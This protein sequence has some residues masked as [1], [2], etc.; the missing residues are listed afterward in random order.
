MV[1]M[2][3]KFIEISWN[4]LWRIVLMIALVAIF[5]IA[6]QAFLAFFLAIVLASAIDPIV[7][8]FERKRFPRGLAV[9]LIFIVGLAILTVLL[10]TVIPI[11]AIELKG[12]F[13]HLE[14]K[15][16]TF[17]KPFASIQFLINFTKGNE[18]IVNALLSGNQ[19]FI[20]IAS[21]FF[22]NIIL[23][24]AAFI[25]TFY[26]SVSKNGVEKFLRAI[27]PRNNEERVIGVYLR[28]R[29]KLGRWLQAQLILSLIIASLSSLGLWLLGVKYSL[30]LGVVAGVLELVP[31]A[32][33]IIAG[34]IA[35]S[36]ALSNS[37]MLGLYVIILFVVLQQLEAHVLLPTIM[38]KTMGVNSAVVVLALLAGYAVASWVGVLLAVPA[39]VTLQEIT[40]DFSRRKAVDQE[41][42][43]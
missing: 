27:L 14:D 6:K 30:L 38:R 25:L 23:L 13:T 24:L 8:F 7:S 29:H 35:F 39:A 19:S 16:P 22:G 33:P 17:L 21:G 32:G 40:N 15:L 31:M 5:L 34:V 3:K 10:Y 9:L 41:E 12:L 18:N 28:V 2:E 1:K 20:D 42:Q 26:L 37:W 4:S 11:A 36:V 43:G